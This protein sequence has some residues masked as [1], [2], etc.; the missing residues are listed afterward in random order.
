MWYERPNM[1]PD[2][3]S[4]SEESMP[5]TRQVALLFDPHR[6]DRRHREL[7]AGIHR[8]A[9][10]APHWRC[11]FDPYGAYDLPGPYHGLIASVGTRAAERIARADL[12]AV[13]A[14]WRATGERSL[15]RVVENRMQAGRLA[16]A[17]LHGQGFRSFACLGLAKDSASWLERQNFGRWLRRRG[18]PVATWLVPHR[19]HFPS[20]IW[21]RTLTDLERWLVALTPPVGIFVATDA[22]ARALADLAQWRGLR[23]PED[24][25]LIGAGNDTPLC[26]LEAP[27][28]TSIEYHH[29]QVGYQ[30]AELLDRLMDGEPPPRGSVLIPPTLIPRRSTARRHSD[31]PLVAQA[32]S[33]IQAHSAQ[34]SR[35]R[36]VADAVGLGL[37]Q[38]QRRMSE[39]RG[40]TITHEIL[41]ARLARA[42]LLLE[43]SDQRPGAIARHTGF[44]SRRH[45]TRAFRQHEGCTPTA[46]RQRHQRPLP[47]DA[48][49]QPDSPPSP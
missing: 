32:V 47:A 28:P 12:P 11:A 44:G 27:S 49:D 23:V 46:Y 30:A 9:Q 31:D 40:R 21:E 36:H 25:G 17:H 24:V 39:R 6:L 26:E 8:F 41:R 19:Y 3:P 14:V 38:L 42:K 29:Q 37:R 5:P 4:V 20:P 2:P 48:A 35:A 18:L 15:T 43:T 45:M 1:T 10:R 13:F 22:L 16:A 34:P 7:L 33:V